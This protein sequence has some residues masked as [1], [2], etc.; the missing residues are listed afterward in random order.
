MA[1]AQPNSAILLECI[2]VLRPLCGAQGYLCVLP[3]SINHNAYV[4]DQ[5]RQDNHKYY[6]L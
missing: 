2:R 5:L 6:R 3:F 1:Q 4:V